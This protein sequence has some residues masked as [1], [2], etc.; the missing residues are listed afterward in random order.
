MNIRTEG[1][2]KII[3]FESPMLM[4]NNTDKSVTLTSIEE[5]LSEVRH[6]N[7]KNEAD[8]KIILPNKVFKVPLT[9]FIKNKS[10]L[11]L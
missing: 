9:W 8:K 10:I 2:K 4:A 6:E 7:V 5:D 11:F 3:S 1:N